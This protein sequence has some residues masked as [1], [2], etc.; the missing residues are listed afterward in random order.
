MKVK[1]YL[2]IGLLLYLSTV[3]AQLSQYEYW[4]DHNFA[5]RVTQSISG[6]EANIT[7]MDVSALPNG[8]HFWYLRV[9]NA[10]GYYS[11]ISSGSFFK[12][13]S[14]MQATLEYWYNDDFEAK[15]EIH[16]V[17]TRDV[18]IDTELDVRNMPFGLNRI[19]FRAIGGAV[20]SSYVL[21]TVAGAS[22]KLEYWFDDDYTN[23]QKVYS[24]VY[25]NEINIASL[26]DVD[27]L[28]EGVHQIH[29]RVVSNV[30]NSPVIS[31]FFFKG[32]TIYND[33][34]TITHAKFWV[35][36]NKAGGLTQE[37]ET[38]RPEINISVLYEDNS[39]QVGEH[40]LNMQ[41][42]NSA[43]IWSVVEICPFEKVEYVVGNIE[44]NATLSPENKVL[45][46]WNS[47]PDIANYKL[48]YN[49]G[50]T[51]ENFKDET[52]PLTIQKTRDFPQGNHSLQIKAY[53]K[54][55]ILIYVSNIVSLQIPQVA[56]NE[57]LLTVYVIDANGNYVD[58]VYLQCK[59]RAQINVPGYDLGWDS[60]VTNNYKTSTGIYNINIPFITQ[61]NITASKEGYIINPG[62]N[63]IFQIDEQT[64]NIAVY[65]NAVAID[66]N[67]QDSILE[68][69][70]ASEIQNL[71]DVD[72]YVDSDVPSRDITV[73]VKNLT[74]QVWKGWIW[75]K[76]GSVENDMNAYYSSNSP[77]VY[78]EIQ[79]QSNLFNGNFNGKMT[80]TFH[81]VPS[82]LFPKTATINVA[83]FSLRKMDDVALPPKLVKATEEYSNP[84]GIYSIDDGQPYLAAYQDALN[85]ALL[86]VKAT[87]AKV[88][89]VHKFLSS[90]HDQLIAQMSSNPQLGITLGGL[91]DYNEGL[92]MTQGILTNAADYF[93]KDSEITK[94]LGDLVETGKTVEQIRQILNGEFFPNIPA[95]P[96]SYTQL[97]QFILRQLPGMEDDKFEPKDFFTIVKTLST[98][99]PTP[100]KAVF[101]PLFTVGTAYLDE[102]EDIQSFLFDN[103]VVGRL[104]LNDGKY[105][106]KIELNEFQGS[107]I[108]SEIKSVQIYG[109]LG[110]TYQ[111]LMDF[112]PSG[113]T[114]NAFATYGR[115]FNTCGGG[116]CTD[117]TNA[118]IK[119]LW[120]NGRVTWV[121][122][123]STFIHYDYSAKTLSLKL[124][125]ANTLKKH[126]ADKLTIQKPS[127][128]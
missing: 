82:T 104:G 66:E 18:T 80:I 97:K 87:L 52:H 116:G 48:L 23:R 58:N 42:M 109:N 27:M 103:Y 67:V 92:R 79:P 7:D 38:P 45:L 127:W 12:Y 22:N 61:G 36:D 107:E 9:K 70:M 71:L 56:D 121:P 37:L 47:M 123:T 76:I 17:D 85:A 25:A 89:S 51:E 102:I 16:L 46:E 94:F 96:T 93:Q 118:Q 75:L 69:E 100:I 81:K 54:S 59:T 99:A 113:N 95:I 77:R 19:N 28:T 20:H 73:T 72:G 49:N 83:L 26:I 74:S 88:N 41:F 110:E 31:E 10:D 115:T 91:Y 30:S 128:W 125:S 33:N 105:S 120:K 29:F 32:R 55:G 4:F 1:Y 62:L 119:I 117:I 8:F 44:L 14:G 64:N 122:V 68:L 6:S 35:D 112:A 5:G 21:K 126:M 50:E 34:Y 43:S 111:K 2:V 63:S 24:D 86:D 84:Y 114:N 106:I 60:E 124:K 39:I 40:K 90:A 57:G 98:N 101:E 11:G 15:K 108:E 13:S 65:F 3:H 53:N 78:A